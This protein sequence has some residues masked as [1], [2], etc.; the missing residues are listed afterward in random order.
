VAPEAGLG[1]SFTAVHDDLTSY[2]SSD[3]ASSRF[4]VAPGPL[5]ALGVSFFPKSVVSLRLEAGS[6]LAS[7]KFE[8]NGQPLDLS[9]AGWYLRPMVEVRL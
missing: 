4:T 3:S 9:L 7:D 6:V 2:G 8:N 1:V 5:L